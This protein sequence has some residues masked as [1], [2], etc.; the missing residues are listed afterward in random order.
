MLKSII[1]SV[2]DKSRLE[3]L[4][5]G[6]F[7]VNSSVEVFSTMGTANQIRKLGFPVK[8]ISFY[9][10]APE[11]PEGNVKTLH[12]K[13]HGGILLDKNRMSERKYLAKNNIKKFGLIVT[14]FY[15]FEKSISDGVSRSDIVE[16][17][18]IGGP[19]LARSAAKGGAET[20]R[21][22]AIGQNFRL[23]SC[24]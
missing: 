21:S 17:I 2:S 4:L 23:W 9:T 3:H 24:G 16:K 5:E 6:I 7:K 18:D 1:I 20:W 22:R 13:I 12:P 10:G 14:N 11:S 8:E 19:T 15:E